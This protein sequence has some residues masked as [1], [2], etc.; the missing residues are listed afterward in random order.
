[1]SQKLWVKYG[2]D[3]ERDIGR[4]SF[5]DCEC[6]ADFIK[7]VGNEVK[8]RIPENI[9]IT[10]YGP[11]GTAIELDEPISSL[12]PGNSPENPLCVQFSSFPL[13][14]TK[15]ASD[16]ELTSF[17]NSLREI[18]NKDGFL[19]FPI[20]PCFLPT[21]MKAIYIRRAYEDLFT[22]ICNNLHPENPKKRCHRITITGTPGIGKSV[23]LFYILW[24]LANEKAA[25]TVV[26]CRESD[27]GRIYVF[28]DD[29]CWRTHEFWDVEKFLKDPSSWYL[30][31]S[32]ESRPAE[33]NATTIWVTSL[34]RR[35]KMVD[36]YIQCV[37]PYYLP[38][39]TLE[40]LKL[41][42]FLYSRDLQWVKERYDLIGGIPRF[43][44]ERKNDLKRSIKHAI[45]IVAICRLSGTPP[46]AEYDE[47]KISH[48]IMHCQVNPKYS[49]YSS[50]FSSK[51]V[52]DLVLEESQDEK[53]NEF[54]P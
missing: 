44:L 47:G 39:W 30:T 45:S 5:K 9:Y 6:V 17:W 27:N 48:F 13:V 16:V 32:P 53:S 36:K 42:A 4:V 18:P 15:L 23:F 43:V 33:V 37:L 29:G 20:R 41:S 31:D 35:D 3:K 52:K 11:S 22:L 51:Y 10:L 8:Y 14:P 46:D 28:Q 2:A 25:K 40:E 34:R 24:R 1:M 12:L 54:L 26:L 7:Q 21:Q 38:V 49:G 19:Y 50:T